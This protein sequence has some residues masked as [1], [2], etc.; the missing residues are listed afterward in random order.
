[1][2]PVEINKARIVRLYLIASFEGSYIFNWIL[3]IK[4][5]FIPNFGYFY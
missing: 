1:M 3:V 2:I 4:V 5:R